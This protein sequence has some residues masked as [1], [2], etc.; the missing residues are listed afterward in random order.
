MTYIK[1]N[2]DIIVRIVL[3]LIVI[4]FILLTVGC[5]KANT[6]ADNKIIYQSY[7]NDELEFE[8]EL[9]SQK[10]S[11]LKEDFDIEPAAY[12]YDV[13]DDGE[14]ELLVSTYYYGF[15]IYDIRSGELI[16]LDHGDGTSDVCVVFTGNDNT[17]VGHSD[18]SHVGRQCLT[19]FKYDSKGEITERISI[20]AFYEDSENDVY[21]ENSEF[22]YNDEEITMD[23]YEEYM[24]MYNSIDFDTIEQAK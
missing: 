5:S 22:T 13:D 10:Y 7:I 18:F 17:Y 16:M 23:Q 4:V 9:F 20:N 12:Y 8:G 6:D 11:Y 14:S 24:A 2:K 15:D 1:Y 21:D 19:L 3:F